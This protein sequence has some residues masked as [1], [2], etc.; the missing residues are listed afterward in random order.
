MIVSLLQYVMW[1]LGLTLM[2]LGLLCTPPNTHPISWTVDLMTSAKPITN[3]F[4]TPFVINPPPTHRCRNDIDVFS[5]TTN[6]PSFHKG[7]MT[8]VLLSTTTFYLTLFSIM[9]PKEEEL[10]QGRFGTVDKKFM[11]QPRRPKMHWLGLFIVNEIRDFGFVR[12]TQLDGMLREGWVNGA[13]K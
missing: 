13:S 5:T 4:V 8:C 1:P 12:L 7:D 9:P 11:K 10:R 6:A 2:L 3:T